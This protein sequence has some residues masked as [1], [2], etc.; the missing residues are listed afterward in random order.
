[1][2]RNEKPMTCKLTTPELQQRKAGT[3]N[4][5]K[6]Q[7]VEKIELH[8][9]YTYKF[10][11]TDSLLDLLTGFVKTERLCCDFFDFNISVKNNITAFLSI[12]GKSRAKEFIEN[13]LEW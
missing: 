1:M 5:L 3:I 6:E 11:A 9:G 12:T 10:E 2:G 4:Y 13:E 7:T 8:N